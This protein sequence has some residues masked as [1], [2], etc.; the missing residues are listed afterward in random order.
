MASIGTYS[1]A[2]YPAVKPTSRRL[3]N[4]PAMNAELANNTLALSDE[5]FNAIL[6]NL[7]S[8]IKKRNQFT[9]MTDLDG[10][11]FDDIQ[12]ML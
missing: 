9:H 4:L 3:A 11:S 7:E 8:A 2:L 12:N 10:Y 1:F 5:A 6:D